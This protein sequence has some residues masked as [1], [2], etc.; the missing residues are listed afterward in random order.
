MFTWKRIVLTGSGLILLVLL[1]VTLVLPGIIITKSQEWVAEETGRSLTVGSISINPFTLAVEVSELSLSERDHAAPF[2]SWKLLRVALSPRSILKWAPIIRDLRLDSPAV[3]LERLTAETFNFS[4]LIPAR[5]KNADPEPAGEPARFAISNLA[6]IDGRIDLIDSSLATQ[7]H[8]TISDLQLVLPMIGNLPYLVE[9][10]AQP[11]FRAV[12]NGSPINLEGKLKPFSTTQEMHFNLN[13]SNI[14]LPFY[15]GY[16][17]FELPVEVRNGGLSIDLD[18]LYRVSAES[19]GELELSGRLN[20]TSLNIWDRL[21]EQLFFLPLLQV[22]IAP[23]QLLQRELHL[24]SV[25]VYNLEV[26]LKRDQHGAWNHARMAEVSP[27]QEPAPEEQPPAAPFKLLVDSFKLR[28]GAVFFEDSLPAGGFSAAARDINLDVRNFALDADNGIPF[29]LALTTDRDENVAVNGHFL[30]N[31]FSLDL[32]AVLGN[33]EV[34]AYEPYY[35]ETYSGPLGGKLGLELNLAVRP[36]Q[37][38]LI[39]EGHLQWREASMAFNEQEGVKVD[40]IELGQLSFDLDRNRLEVGSFLY[41]NGRANFSRSHEGHWS[42]LSQNFPVLTKLTEAPEEKTAPE[43]TEQGPVFSYRIGELSMVNGTFEVSDYLPSTPT[44][45]E[46][47]DFNLTFHN[48]AAPEKVESPFTLSTTFQSKGRIEISGSASLANQSIRLDSRLKQIPLATFAPYLAEQASLA[49]VDGL[50]DAQLNSTVEAGSGPLKIAFAGDIGVSRFHL[51]DALHRE[52][53]LKWDSL[54]LAGI[55]AQVAPLAL[56]VQSITLS[57]YFAKVL[58]DEEARLNLVEAFRKPGAAPGAETAEPA[59]EKTPATAPA[60]A[61]TQ[62]AAPPD[63]RIETVTLQGGLV[64][65]TDRS[66]P[67]PFHA[68][69]RE[70][71]GSIKGLSSAAE[72]RASVDLRGSLRNQSPLSI[73]GSVNPLA[74]R[75]FLDLKLSFNDIELSPLSP[76]SGTYVGYLIKKGKLNL[77]LEYFLEDGKLKANNQVFLDQF[78]FGDK[79]ESD[80]ATT[81]PVKLAVALLKD[82][83][84]EIHMDIPVSGSLDDPQFSI[85]GVVWTIIRNLIVKA[86]TSPFALLGALVGGGDQDFSSVS[87]DYGSSRLGP[88]QKDKLQHMAQALAERPGLEIE[89]SGFVDP[90]QDVEG[91]R[92]Q[93][94]STQVKRLKY[95]D[96]V[97]AGELPEGPRE[98]DVTVPDEEY[99]DYLWEVYREADFPKPRNFIGIT[100]KLPV[101]EMEKLIYTNTSVTGNDLAE[102]AQARAMAVQNFLIEQGKLAQ[103]RIFLQ[104]TDITSAPDKEATSRARVEFGVAVH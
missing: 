16:V 67:R 96:L 39:S 85:T 9:E 4:D 95:L 36:G 80:K 42:F 14:D 30:V 77:A 24:A 92:R 83:K 65:F 58:I 20:L 56:A 86:A 38:L 33:I 8:H 35:R 10:P 103:E 88:D 73:S 23:S 54:Q 25:H 63:I 53:L 100:R 1:F 78:T 13:L 61:A 44:K 3:H 31:P 17:P 29:E 71:G 59:A 18:I 104:E 52:D 101:P 45:L 81:L 55:N 43:R 66:L 74:E 94:L 15:L 99:A 64:D 34:G 75:L 32:K 47:R 89:V 62:A 28:D 7:V 84:G 6:I 69:M 72:T 98:E 37:R 48:L 26:Q 70:L 5:D 51:L 60:E 90:E 19:G 41:Q 97:K 12:F 50:L 76:Y 27:R 91:Y 2:I 79:V 82:S 22:E 11:L 93:Q 46:A 87:F 57:D 21:D 102:L 49:L 40:L 68:D